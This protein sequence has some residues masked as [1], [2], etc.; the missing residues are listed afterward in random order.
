MRKVVDLHLFDDRVALA[1][2]KGPDPETLGAL[3][4]FVVLCGLLG[5]IVGN[6]VGR[7]IGKNAMS[8]RLARTATMPAEALAAE[9]AEVVPTTSI[10]SLVARHHGSGGRV[11]I[12]LADGTT[13]KYS[14]SKAYVKDLDVDRLFHDAAPG[15]TVV[16]PLSTARKV[17]RWAGV[18]FV[19]L[20]AVGI[21]A[22]VIVAVVSPE[23]KSVSSVSAGL[24][25]DVAVPLG[26]ACT[27]WSA[28]GAESDPSVERI[29]ATI[30]QVRPDLEQVASVDPSFQQAADSIAFLD[31]YFTTPTAEQQP[32]VEG[33]AGDV[34]AACARS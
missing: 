28:L 14:W 23:S 8:T 12:A 27:A 19:A 34:D 18:A 16:H 3:L 17:A 2:V 15:R 30:V 26:R 31:G 22:A 5:A 33:A 11:R 4:G 10:T 32:Q 24:P 13:R 25:D 7:A 20:M 21:V 1:P 6:A 29:K 9:G